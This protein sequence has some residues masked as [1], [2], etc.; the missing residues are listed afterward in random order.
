V[1]RDHD[2][3]APAWD[4]SHANWVNEQRAA[5]ACSCSWQ[6][7][8]VVATPLHVRSAARLTTCICALL[9][10]GL[11]T[12]VLEAAGARQVDAGVTCV[13]SFALGDNATSV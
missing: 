11:R 1:P 5:A 7:S 12:A 6:P 9:V 8:H 3:A 2:A 4:P 10:Q 13:D